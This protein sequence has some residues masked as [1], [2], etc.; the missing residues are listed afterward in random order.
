MSEHNSYTCDTSCRLCNALSKYKNKSFNHCIIETASFV[1]LPGL[2]AIT[3]G[4]SIIVS[5]KHVPNMTCFEQEELHE[6]SRLV[7]DSKEVISNALGENTIFTVGEHGSVPTTEN[8]AGCITHFHLHVFPV[9]IAVPK[10]ILDKKHLTISSYKQIKQA[11]LPYILIQTHES[12]IYI[13]NDDNF[14]KQYLR[15]L[16]ASHLGKPNEWNWK[17]HLEISRIES[18]LSNLPPQFKSV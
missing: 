15:K 18:F 11:P 16:V 9:S 5:K 6:L 12:E 14:P 2:G 4:Y 1:L 3:E 10:E 8:S 17:E 7:E 13:V